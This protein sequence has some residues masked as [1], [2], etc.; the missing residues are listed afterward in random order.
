MTIVVDVGRV[1]R[2]H[3]LGLV[4]HEYAHAQVGKPGHD[5]AFADVLNH[6]CLG[7]GLPCPGNT[8]AQLKSYPGGLPVVD[9]LALWRG[10]PALSLPRQ[11]QG[12]GG[13][14]KQQNPTEKNRQGATVDSIDC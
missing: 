12:R 4:A 2:H 5:Q 3:W 1:E 6:L 14:R 13:D 11:G 10:T 7:L 8:E 9:A